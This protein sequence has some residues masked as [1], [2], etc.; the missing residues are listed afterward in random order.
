MEAIFRKNESETNEFTAKAFLFIYAF[1]LLMGA[2][3]G[4]GI[5][6]INP[7]MVWLFVGITFVPLVLPAILIY[8]FHINK[9][10]LKYLLI[11]G[12]GLSVGVCYFIFTFQSVIIFVVPSVIAA[13]Y[14]N[15]RLLWYS[16]ILTCIVII[17]AHIATGFYMFQPWIEPFLDIKSILQYGAIPRCMQ[18]LLCFAL[19][20]MLNLRHLHYM[21]TMADKNATP[22]KEDSDKE[23]FNCLLTL[24]SER[25][26]DVFLLM[27]NGYTNKQIAD[28]LYLSMGTVKNYVSMIYEK[29]GNKERTSLI[30]KYSRFCE[31]ND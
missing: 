29:T 18:Y 26:K 1:I 22:E 20:V 15:K 31:E 11:S 30:L 5:F 24:L 25:E 13:F 16:G 9:P 12:L 23:E 7:V 19:L 8:V 27:A 4:I 21:Q 10:W 28:K 17:A 2:L 14:M 3:C 6:D